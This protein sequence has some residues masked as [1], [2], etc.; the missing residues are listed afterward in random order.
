MHQARPCVE[1]Y[2]RRTNWAMEVF[3]PEAEITLE[4]VGVTLPTAVVYRRVSFPPGPS[5]ES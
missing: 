1:V 4:S 3:E 2:R 5:E